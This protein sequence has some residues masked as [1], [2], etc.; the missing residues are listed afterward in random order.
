MH[1]TSKQLPYMY[2]ATNNIKSRDCLMTS[3]VMQRLQCKVNDELVRYACQ[4]CGFSFDLVGVSKESF[5]QL[6][7]FIF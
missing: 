4:K 1:Y 7:P 5:F 2:I 3:L 6:F